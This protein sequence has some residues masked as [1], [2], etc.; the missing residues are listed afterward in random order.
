MTLNVFVKHSTNVSANHIIKCQ[1]IPHYQVKEKGAP[2]ISWQFSFSVSP[3][4]PNPGF[5]QSPEL[6]VT[7]HQRHSISA[8]AFLRA[9]H[10]LQTHLYGKNPLLLPG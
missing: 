10:E 8:S 2:S 6:T 5:S 9:S 7:S 3:L 1:F 4:V